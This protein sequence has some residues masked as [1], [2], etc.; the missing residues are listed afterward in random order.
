MIRNI[1]SQTHT[2]INFRE[3]MDNQRILL[4]RL[5][6][7]YEE[8]SRLIGAVIIGKILLAAFS[9]ADTPEH[10]RAQFS[11]YADEYQRYAS[12]G[13]KTLISE[14]RKFRI[15]TTLSH[16]TLSQLD[17]ANRTAAAVAGNL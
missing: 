7:E 17:E 4:V 2:S 3:I 6:P 5:S 9:R 15:A 8:A 13:M 11:L 1:F 10:R 12:S 14:A 16:Q